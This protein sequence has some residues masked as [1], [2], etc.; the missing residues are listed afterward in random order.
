MTAQKAIPRGE[1]ILAAVLY[2]LFLLCWGVSQ[3]LKLEG[4]STIASMVLFYLVT[5]PLVGVGGGLLMVHRLGLKAVAV[6]AERWKPWLGWVAF[7]LVLLSGVGNQQGLP[8]LLRRPPALVGVA[9]YLVLF[10]PMVLALSLWSFLIIPRIVERLVPR[11]SMKGLSAIVVAAVSMGLSFYVDQLFGDFQFAGIMLILGAL[12]ATGAVMTGSFGNTLPV[13][14][15]MMLINTLA[16][17]KY[18]GEPWLPLLAGLAI[19]LGGLAW[20]VVAR[21]RSGQR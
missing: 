1:L 7:A 21:R 8:A 9:K 17:A 4:Q 20:F 10:A 3:A 19:A 18:F 11:R 14:F 5:M 16:E 15:V 6:P 13:F 2:G 12:T